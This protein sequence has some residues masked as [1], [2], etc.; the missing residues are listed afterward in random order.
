[1]PSATS[2]ATAATPRFSSV[3]SLRGLTV[4]AMLLVNNAGDWNHIHPWL[5]HAP[6]HGCTPA[7]LI[8]PLF[9][10]IAGV[11]LSLALEPQRELG[12]SPAALRL[13]VLWRAARVFA[14]GLLLHL[15]AALLIPERDLRLPG[16]LQRIGLCIAV[17]GPVALYLK[18]RAQWVLAGALLIGYSLLL[19]FTGVA[20][21][22]NPAL[23][24][25]SAVLGRFAYRYDPA[26][27][28]AF[29]PEGLVS[30][31]GAVMTTL[32]GLR[33]GHW[34]RHAR[35][36][37][38]AAAGVAAIATGAWLHLLQPMNKSLWT[39]AF[40]LWSGGIA[41]LALL[42]AHWLADRRGLW[43]PGGA[44]GRNA[45]LA[46]AGSWLMVCMLAATGADSWL[47]RHAFASWLA[48]LAGSTA[49]SAAWA[50]A[51]TGVWWLVSLP[52]DRKRWYWKI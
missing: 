1:M 2:A 45:I 51:V 10:F 7:D 19:A 3:D 9:L 47:Y 13:A 22:H 11:S 44:L 34:L 27:G 30:T 24:I 38:L 37:V 25:D 16:V 49:A 28:L 33:A 52:L 21:D 42:A 39:P 31:L 8:F 43:L 18:P 17:A 35:L 5:Q 36:A 15:V 6:W 29:D 46:Y 12:R 4:A 40:V 14:L 50:A 41:C 26:T 20:I 32:L 48:P 23:V